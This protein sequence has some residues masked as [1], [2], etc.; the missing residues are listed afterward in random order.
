MEYT[1]FVKFQSLCEK[2]MCILGGFIGS[3][4]RVHVQ[5]GAADK[6]A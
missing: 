4:A 3:R 1:D 6:K 5:H 2:V